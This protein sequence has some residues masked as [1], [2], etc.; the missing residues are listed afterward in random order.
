MLPDSLT[1][2]PIGL[3]SGR[4][5]ILQEDIQPLGA[6]GTEANSLSQYVLASI[7]N[8]IANSLANITPW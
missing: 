6:L 4:A 7:A 5:G 2:W 1:S 3:G 8:N